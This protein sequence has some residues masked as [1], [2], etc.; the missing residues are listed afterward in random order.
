M[1]E[2]AALVIDLYQKFLAWQ[3]QHG[4]E[5]TYGFYF[6]PQDSFTAFLGAR[7]RL[8]DVRPYH[9]QEWLDAK[10]PTASQTYRYNLIRA[11]KRPFLWAKKLGYILVDPLE[12]VSRGSQT[13]R[14]HYLEPAQWNSLLRMVQP[15]PFRDFLVLLRATGA[16]PQEVR[17]VESRHFDRRNECWRFPIEESKMECQERIIHLNDAKGIALALT[18]S[19]RSSIL[20]GRSSAT[21]RASRGP[22]DR[23]TCTSPACESA[24]KTRWTFLSRATSFDTPTPRTLWRPAWMYRLWRH[25]WATVT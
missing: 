15:G 4:S 24:R 20:K 16:R 7:K 22:A 13:S 2:S 12:S 1:A 5:T 11:V 8:R 10:Y 21:R 19:R 17:A 25:E 3:K 18:R 14:Q 6:A 23:W 9:V